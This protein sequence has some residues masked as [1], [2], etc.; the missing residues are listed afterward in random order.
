MIM[1]IR[2]LFLLRLPFSFCFCVGEIM[3]GCVFVGFLIFFF[4]LLNIVLIHWIK[5][6]GKGL[7]A[8]NVKL[9][10]A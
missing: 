10:I 7:P 2:A 9:K 1:F 3:G 8:R 6:V 5:M 4:K